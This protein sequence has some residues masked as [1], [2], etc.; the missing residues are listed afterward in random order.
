MGPTTEVTGRTL[1]LTS[2]MGWYRR[3]QTR[4]LRTPPCR[5]HGGGS[6]YGEHREQ[7]SEVQVQVAFMSSALAVGKERSERLRPR[8]TMVEQ[9]RAVLHLQLTWLQP[10]LPCRYVRML[11]QDV[12]C[13]VLRCVAPPHAHLIVLRRRS[14]VLLIC[15]N[16][17]RSRFRCPRF[18]GE[19]VAALP[20]LY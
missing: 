2:T 18:E 4:R 15:R 14:K 11:D 20:P 9:F 17:H 13:L 7:S 16:V 10:P 8:T 6:R 19:A 3:P 1:Y 12:P 5:G